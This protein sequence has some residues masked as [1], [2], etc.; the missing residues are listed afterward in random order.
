MYF[1]LAIGFNA[2]VIRY[3]VKVI[4][5]NAKASASNVMVIRYSSTLV[6]T[7]R[8]IPPKEKPLLLKN[9]S[10]PLLMIYRV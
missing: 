2:L 6:S 10:Y 8:P 4:K 7:Y 3:D 5:Y 9:P 1:P